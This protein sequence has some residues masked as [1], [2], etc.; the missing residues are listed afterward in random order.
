MDFENKVTSVTT[1]GY[2]RNVILALEPEHDPAENVHYPPTTDNTIVVN[3]IP[4]TLRIRFTT[5]NDLNRTKSSTY[6]TGYDSPP[7][8]RIIIEWIHDDI[9]AISV[10]YNL[11]DKTILALHL[12]KPEPVFL[13]YTYNF[14]DDDERYSD[15]HIS[16]VVPH[17]E[18]GFHEP[19]YLYKNDEQEFRDIIE[20]LLFIDMTKVNSFRIACDRL[21]RSYYDLFF[22]DKLIDLC[23][24]Y[25]ALYL[26]GEK[27]LP[28]IGM[29]R[30]IG[31]KCSELLT[32][33]ME[34]R[35]KISKVIIDSFIQRNHIV[36]GRDFDFDKI[37]QIIPEF[38]GYLR[39]S[40][41]KLMTTEKE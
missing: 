3:L 36:H 21:K 20:K 28:N 30:F 13:T 26:K 12:L 16:L 2:L 19:Y 40:L 38:R 29:G 6:G 11:I 9:H 27:Y 1:H 37:L 24:G 5:D 34:N 25:E 31:S 39:Q 22:E 18:D 33:N 23:I 41:L 15:K 10:Y 17:P 7:E 32:D 14:L 8:E 4:K 35:E